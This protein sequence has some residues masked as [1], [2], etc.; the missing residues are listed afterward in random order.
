MSVR[1]GGGQRAGGGGAAGFLWRVFFA[2]EGKPGWP[3]GVGV[4]ELAKVFQG[5]ADGG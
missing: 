4:E 3:G 2:F 5:G 1:G